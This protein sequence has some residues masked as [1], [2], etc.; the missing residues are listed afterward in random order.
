MQSIAAV[1]L[2]RVLEDERNYSTRSVPQGLVLEG[3]ELISQD[4]HKQT[5]EDSDD[6]MTYLVRV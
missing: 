3:D 1:L 2:L 6:N 5:P 4:W